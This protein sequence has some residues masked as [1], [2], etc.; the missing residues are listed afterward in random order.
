MALAPGASAHANSKACCNA[1]LAGAPAL[2][3]HKGCLGGAVAKEDA[4]APA[5]EVGE[6]DVVALTWH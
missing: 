5:A 3:R 2:V 1:A 6:V 4:E